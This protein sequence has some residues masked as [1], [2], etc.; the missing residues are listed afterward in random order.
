V[1][2]LYNKQALYTFKNNRHW[3]GSTDVKSLDGVD[4][5]PDKPQ[6]TQKN[7][8]YTKPCKYYNLNICNT[9]KCSFLHICGVCGRNHKSR[10]FHPGITTIK[11]I[12]C[13]KYNNETCNYNNIDCDYLH[14]CMKCKKQHTY[15]DCKYIIIYCPLCNITMNSTKEYITHHIDPI[16]LKKLN[17]LTK[18]AEPY[19]SP[20][21]ENRH[22]LVV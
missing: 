9:D 4:S 21:S 11:N 17:I 19:S 7:T 13:K 10:D 20:V 8:P 1:F 14:I 18:I 22:I 6:H 3:L 12:I 15:V 16:H 2:L 5:K